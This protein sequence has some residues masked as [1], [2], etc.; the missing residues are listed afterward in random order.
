MDCYKNDSLYF[1]F[2]QVIRLHYHRI[3]TLLDKIGVYPGQ[4]QMLFFLHIK[5][6]QSQKELAEKLHIKPATITVMLGRMEKAEL[7][8]RRQDSEDQRVSRVYL[9]EKGREVWEEV[10]EIMKMLEGECFANFTT[11]EQVLMRRLLMQ[12]RDNLEKVCDKKLSFCGG[13]DCKHQE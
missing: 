5:D 3:R 11:E 13:A 4:P 7:L 2:S 12:V 6:G 1:L 8:E 9:T 10:S